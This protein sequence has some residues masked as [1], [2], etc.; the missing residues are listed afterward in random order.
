M[1]Y[2]IKPRLVQTDFILFFFEFARFHI[3]A[4]WSKNDDYD[5]NQYGIYDT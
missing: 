3:C 5:E 1:G 2:Y 4:L